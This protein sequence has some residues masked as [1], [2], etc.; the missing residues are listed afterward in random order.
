MT[1][2]R[3]LLA[4]AA[5]QAGDRF[6]ALSAIFDPVTFAH[7]DALGIG[8]GWRCWEVGAGGMSVP[9]WMAS[10][11]GR[12]G[13]VLATDIDISWLQGVGAGVDVR[14]HDVATD[15]PPGDGFDLVHAR[16]VLVHVAARDEALRRMISALRPGGWLVVEDFDTALVSA[17]C[18]E[19]TSGDQQ[20]ANRIRQG[21]CHLLAGR[22]VDLEYGR[23]LPRVLRDGGLEAVAAEAY[24]AVA[25]P[26]SPLLETANTAQVAA[27]LVE[28]GWAT[29]TEIDDHLAALDRGG[30]DI[31]TPPLISAWGRRPH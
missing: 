15:E 26:A 18:L 24:F 29:H 14:Q 13:H 19:A 8:A 21:F 7:I 16:L 4:N 6:A 27:A 28:G 9:R 20:R 17:S 1:A 3:Y 2:N 22:G 30:L 10:K 5:I 12:T 31:A 11:V 25:H 23:K